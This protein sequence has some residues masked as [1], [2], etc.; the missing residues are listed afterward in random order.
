MIGKTLCFMFFGLFAFSVF[1]SSVFHV[2]FLFVFL[3]ILRNMVPS[4]VSVSP[5]LCPPFVHHLS[6]C[7]LFFLFMFLVSFTFF[8][9]FK[10]PLLVVVLSLSF[11]MSN[12]LCKKI[13]LDFCKTLFFYLLFSV[14]ISVFS[15]SFFCWANLFF[16][17]LF[18]CLLKKWFLIFV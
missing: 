7:S 6:I 13:F 9:L 12:S 3:D 8:W 14:E 10:L 4:K 18:F 15:V 1:L 2:V 11:F 16:H 5:F 17:V